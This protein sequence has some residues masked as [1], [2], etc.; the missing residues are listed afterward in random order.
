MSEN[1]KKNLIMKFLKTIE[2]CGVEEEERLSYWEDYK[3]YEL[4]SETNVIIADPSHHYGILNYTKVENEIES[5]WK[6]YSLKRKLSLAKKAI[7]RL[8]FNGNF[9]SL[10]YIFNAVPFLE[11][12]EYEI[13]KIK[14]G[15]CTGLCFKIDDEYC[16][17]FGDLA[18]PCYEIKADGVWFIDEE[19]DDKTEDFIEIGREFVKWRDNVAIR[20]VGDRERGMKDYLYDSKYFFEEVEEFGSYMML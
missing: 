12:I 17:I 20:E 13:K 5:S 6:S 15:S 3:K 9:Y 19:F 11:Q 14:A 2:V 1:Y 18:N 7:G 16:L 8:H 4:K 10:A